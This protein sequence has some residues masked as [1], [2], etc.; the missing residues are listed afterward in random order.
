MYKVLIVDDEI[1]IRRGLSKIIKWEQIG[2]E[3]VGAVG[4]AEAA[5]KILEDQTVDVLL[6]D[7]SMPEMSGLDLIR[8]VKERQPR[9]KTVVISGYSEFD[10]AV[11]AIKLKVENYILKPLDPKKIT[12]IFLGLKESLN[13]ERKTEQKELYL[14]S[15]YE[16]LRG[17]DA[18]N[19]GCQ[20]ETHTQLIQIL[21]EGYHNKLDAFVEDFFQTYEGS[22]NIYVRDDCIRA[23]RN[24]ALY[25]H[26]ENPP[27]FHIY[28]L[29]QK[30]TMDIDAIKKCFKADLYLLAGEI[31]NHSEST[32]TLVS[33]Q[34]RRYIEENYRK[35][36]LS[37][38]D[39]ADQLGVSYSYLSTAFSKTYGENFKSYLVSVRIEK[40]RELLMERTYK[41]F[42][43]A[44]MVG[45]GSSRYF[46]DAFKRRYGVSP[47]DYLN[48]LNCQ[49]RSGSD[50]K[51]NDL[52]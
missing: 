1:V 2:F 36:S 4:D 44:D 5:L 46:S 6:T 29:E 17:M 25:F 34:A 48:R 38:R 49:K 39:A 21:E 20:D 42:E 52:T 41:I 30:E 28:R 27:F 18:K 43:I 9:I 40:A 24:V 8:A 12:E 13:K 47:V 51:K 7:I 10:Y 15:E 3:M 19:K 50:E 16:L 33:S 22:D 26:L 14:Q 32:V 11:E 35:K 23:L 45:Y 37:L 31:S